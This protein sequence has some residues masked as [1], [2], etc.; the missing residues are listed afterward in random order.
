MDRACNSGLFLPAKLECLNYCPLYLHVLTVSNVTDAKGT[1]F[2]PSILDGI[3][4]VQQST[5]KGPSAKQE[6][7]SDDT[8][9]LWRRL[10]RTFGNKDQLFLP[11]GSWISSGPELRRDWLTLFSPEYRQIYRQANQKY[12]V[13]SL[14]RRCIYSFLSKDIQAEVQDD[15]ISVDAT[16][17]SDGW[18]VMTP[19]PTLY[20]EECIDFPA[21]FQDYADLLP[22]YDA[23]LIQRVDFLG[24]DIY[25]T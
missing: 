6:R 19:S 15:A 22:N 17:V 10:V 14:V 23:M 18:R 11:L 12:E 25:E 20:P 3:R 1:Q 9:A 13:C 2:A 24:I 21:T 7:P 5:S 4:S 8:W 16:E